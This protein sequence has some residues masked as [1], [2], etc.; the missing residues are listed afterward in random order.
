MSDRDPDE[1]LAPSEVARA[2]HRD[3]VMSAEARALMDQG[4]G[5]FKRIQQ[6][7]HLFLKQAQEGAV[8]RKRAKPKR[9]RIH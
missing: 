6:K 8:K 2:R 3:R 4:A 5:Q 7:A 1:Y 9:K